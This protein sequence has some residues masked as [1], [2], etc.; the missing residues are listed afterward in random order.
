LDT[1]WDTTVRD[2]PG[3]DTSCDSTIRDTPGLGYQLGYDNMGYT[4][5]G[6]QLGYDSLGHTRLGNLLGYIKLGLKLLN[7]RT[8]TL[9]GIHQAEIDTPSWGKGCY[10]LGGER[11]PA[12]IQQAKDTPGYDTR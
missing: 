9:V 6:N 5:L 11:I 10:T 7:T 2:T 3:W 8:G 4:R 1:S 12:E